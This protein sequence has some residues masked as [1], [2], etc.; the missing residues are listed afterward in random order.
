M[1][2]VFMIGTVERHLHDIRKN[3]VA[4]MLLARGSPVVDVGVDVSVATFGIRREPRH[5]CSFIPL[6]GDHA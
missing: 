6:D 1:G 2:G 4:I 5:T 3:L